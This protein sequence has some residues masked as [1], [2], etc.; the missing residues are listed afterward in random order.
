M[1][2]AINENPVVKIALIG[3]LVIL[4]GLFFTKRVLKRDKEPSSTPVAQAAAPGVAPAS[5]EAT[6]GS[7]VSAP[8]AATSV[9]TT[10]VPGPP[11]PPPV[12]AAYAGDE[13]V[14]LLVV[15]GGGIDDGLVRGAVER[16]RDKPSLA[17]FV[18]NAKGI[19][20]YSRI[21]SGVAVNRVPA[22]IVVRPQRLSSGVPTAHVS[23][24]FRGAES[25]VQA[26]RDAV[27]KGPTLPYHPN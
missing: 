4:A 5:A 17:V 21:T 26:V 23:Y 19:A 24:G 18:T 9:P 15:R 13:T 27:Y 14:V 1:R 10:G 8:A 22:L 12:R 2:R 7:A 11:L 6:A 16:L 25:V 3:V 20:R